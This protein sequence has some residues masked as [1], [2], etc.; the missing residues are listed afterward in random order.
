MFGIHGFGAP[1]F[2]Q[3]VRDGTVVIVPI[4][5][6]EA[7]VLVLVDGQVREIEVDAPIRMFTVDAVTRLI[8]V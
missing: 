1:Y 8:D 3:A 4:T 2:G 7:E 6:T 5:V